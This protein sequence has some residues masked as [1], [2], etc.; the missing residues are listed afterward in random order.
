MR[1]VIFLAKGI[2]AYKFETSCTQ[3]ASDRSVWLEYRVP[4]HQVLVKD[5][6]V[7]YYYCFILAIGNH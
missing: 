3:E 5:C 1:G 6:S 4:T 2:R 7:F